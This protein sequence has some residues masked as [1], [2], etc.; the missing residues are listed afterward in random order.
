M[1]VH[2]LTDGGQRAEEVAELVAAFLR[3]AR[4]GRSSLGPLR[5]PPA[6][7]SRGPG[8]RRAPR[9]RR[10][11]GSGP[12]ALQRRLRR[13]PAIQPPPSTRPELLHELPIEDRAV[14]GIP[15]L[16]HHKYVVRD[17]EAVW[18]GVGELD[19]RLAGRARRTC[20]RA[21]SAALAARLRRATSRSSGS[22]ATS[23]ARAASSRAGRARARGDRGPRLVHA[24]ARRGALAGDRDRD[25]RARRRVR[26]ASPVITSAPIL[27]TLAELGARGGV[28]VAGVIDEPQTDAVYGQWA[29]NG[30][31]AWK[32]PLL[33]KALSLLPFSG[34]PSTPWGPGTV[35]DFMHAKVTVADDTV[36]VG[37]FNLS[38]S[39]EMNAE[40]VLELR[41]PELAERMAAFVDAVRGRYPATSV[42]AQAM[43]TIS[44]VSLGELGISKSAGRDPPRL[45]QLGP[46]PVE[47]PRPVVAADEDDRVVDRLAG[48]DQGQHLEQLVERPVAARQDDDRVRVAHEHQ[49]AG[50]EVVEGEADVDSRG[51]AP[52]RTGSR[53][54]SPTEVAPA[55]RAPRLA[56]SISPG[57]PPV[58]TA[59]PAS[60]IARPISRARAYSGSLGRR[61][62]R[63]EDADRGADLAPAPRSPGAAPSRPAP[64]ARSSVRVEATAGVSAQMISSPR[65]A[66]SRGCG[67][68]HCSVSFASGAA[69][70][71]AS[72]HGSIRKTTATAR[73]RRRRRHRPRARRPARDR[74]ADGRGRARA[75]SSSASGPRP[76]TPPAQTVRDAIEIGAR[77]L[78]REGTA[79]EV[80]YV[81]AEFERQAA[82][83]ARAAR[84]ALESG[85]E[86]LAE[87]I[88]ETFDGRARRLG[89]EGHRRAAQ[90]GARPSSARRC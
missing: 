15:D 31:S 16:M 78:E 88:T 8:R 49:L 28:D 50:E 75:R 61:A 89:A 83:A 64:A 45:E 43:A 72:S 27:A 81:R 18:T 70:T 37:S 23:S 32:I 47:Q 5:H 39:G 68:A 10:R 79:V 11:A 35:H 85:D 7:A 69:T 12:P 74:A 86:L 71:L 46:H 55:S 13:P 77:V 25:R 14:P 29:T 34:K 51:S 22:A 38:R 1:E 52:A 54:L 58:I 84:R 21:R 42:P 26:I 67:S 36:F 90:A 30:I 60:P 17:R 80:D 63:A 48:L 87:R 24:R 19:R 33:A 56:A 59:N 65:V 44:D 82:R 76:A 3:P 73:R 6:R 40:N 57:P 66:G 20:R 41:D 53:M 9:G 2:E 4:T 62:R